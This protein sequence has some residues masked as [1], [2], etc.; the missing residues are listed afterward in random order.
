[1]NFK[2]KSGV[3]AP[4]SSEVEYLMAVILYGVRKTIKFAIFNF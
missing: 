2:S 4:H 1:M 3:K